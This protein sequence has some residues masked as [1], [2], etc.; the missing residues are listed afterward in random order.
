M[1]TS[2]KTNNEK[3]FS[4][5]GSSI[6]DIHILQFFVVATAQLQQQYLCRT[7]LFHSFLIHFPSLFRVAMPGFCRREHS[8]GSVGLSMMR[9]H[10]GSLVCQKSTGLALN[11]KWS[12]VI[13]RFNDCNKTKQHML[14]AHE[15]A[16]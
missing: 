2:K 7:Q 14:W 16:N 9:S 8:G 6:N 10:C 3:S 5:I 13:F 11:N 15:V 12:L 4:P 1:T